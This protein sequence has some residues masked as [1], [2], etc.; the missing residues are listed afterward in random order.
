MKKE[1]KLFSTAFLITQDAIFLPFKILKR[2]AKVPNT[3]IG[4]AMSTSA[5][6]TNITTDSAMTT[7]AV[8]TC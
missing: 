6:T 8:T 3:A 4:T 1:L 5:A 2:N 7:G